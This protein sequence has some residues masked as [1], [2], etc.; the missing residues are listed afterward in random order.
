MFNE[1]RQT[2]RKVL[3]VKA[4]LAMQD[5]PP[6]T[7]RTVDVAASGVCITAPAPV[8]MGAAGKVS[9]DLYHDGKNSAIAAKVKATYCIFSNGEFKIGFQFTNLELSAMSALAKYLR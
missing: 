2:V 5:A 3:K 8:P 4:V 9:F 6:V 7:V 1:Q